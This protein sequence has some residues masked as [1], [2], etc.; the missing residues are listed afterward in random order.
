MLTM[1]S[2]F[3]FVEKLHVLTSVWWF[4]PGSQTGSHIENQLFSFLVK[5]GL[6]TGFKVLTHVRTN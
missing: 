2:I 1:S 6:K 4:T 3:E 5:T